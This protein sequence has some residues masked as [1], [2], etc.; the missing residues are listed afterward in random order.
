MT[1]T[2]TFDLPTLF[3]IEKDCSLSVGRYANNNHIAIE[4]W[5]ADG[6]YATLTVN[7]PDAKRYPENY[8]FVDTNNFP[9]GPALIER[10][11][12]GERTEIRATSGFCSYPL[13]RFDEAAVHDYAA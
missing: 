9:Q 2:K 4:I 5:C 12:I 1:G 13:Y 3:G 7:L 11:G 10:L 6:P 8:A